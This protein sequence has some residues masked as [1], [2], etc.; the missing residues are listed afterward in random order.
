MSTVVTPEDKDVEKF[1]MFMEHYDIISVCL[2][3]EV[4]TFSNG[5]VII[6]YDSDGRLRKIKKEQVVFN[7]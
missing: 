4:F 6:S 1:K 5:N 3:K 7:S 2:D